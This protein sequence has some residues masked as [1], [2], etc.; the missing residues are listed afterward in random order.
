MAIYCKS[1][2]VIRHK[3]ALFELKSLFGLI[4]NNLAIVGS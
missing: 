1:F 2:K 3:D 4:M